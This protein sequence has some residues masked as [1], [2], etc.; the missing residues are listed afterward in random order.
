MSMVLV[1]Q[2]WKMKIEEFME[3]LHFREQ[4][5][6]HSML[7]LEPQLGDHEEY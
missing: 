3:L 4:F 1:L 7:N 2:T 5:K 6:T